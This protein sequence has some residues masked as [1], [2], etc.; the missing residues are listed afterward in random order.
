MPVLTE[1]GVIALCFL[2]NGLSSVTMILANKRLSLVFPFPFLCI[3]LQNKIVLFLTWVILYVL[4]EL[5]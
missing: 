3:F 4:P 5:F 1:P 2:L